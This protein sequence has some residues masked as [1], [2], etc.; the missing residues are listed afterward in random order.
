MEIADGISI[1]LNKNKEVIGIEILNASRI[2]APFIEKK[3]QKIKF[4]E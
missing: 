2:L 4:L 1:E 3:L